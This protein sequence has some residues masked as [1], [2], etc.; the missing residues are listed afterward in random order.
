MGAQR[1]KGGCTARGPVSSSHQKAW[2]CTTGNMCLG[3][4][5]H[6]HGRNCKSECQ[7][8][9]NKESPRWRKSRDEFSSHRHQASPWASSPHQTNEDT[10]SCFTELS[11]V[12]KW[13][14]VEALN[15][16]PMGYHFSDVLREGWIAFSHS[17]R[18]GKQS[19]GPPKKFFST[20]SSNGESFLIVHAVS[21]Q[22][23]QLMRISRTPVQLEAKG[24]W[25]QKKWWSRL[26]KK[27]PRRPELQFTS[28]MRSEAGHS[29]SKLRATGPR[30][31]PEITTPR[32]T[33]IVKVSQVSVTF[34]SHVLISPSIQFNSYP[35]RIT[36]F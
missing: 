8:A 15:T 14:C 1:Q 11:G 4:S 17:E 33:N 35:S 12:R 7:Q 23:L 30:S 9:G 20:Q 28:H 19:C 5:Q 22:T 24:S 3:F 16:F 18:E 10:N 29:R 34:S 6:M 25:G 21:S 31:L 26:P 27:Y 13:P 2:G 32:L 36:A